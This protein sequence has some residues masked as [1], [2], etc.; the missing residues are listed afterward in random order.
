MSRAEWISFAALIISLSSAAAAWS[1]F[2]M[3]RRDRKISAPT[4]TYSGKL[5]A[6]SGLLKLAVVEPHR[7]AWLLQGLAITRPDGATIQRP[8]IA[9][10]VHGEPETRERISGPSRQLSFEPPADQAFVW[11]NAMLTT[12][13]EV[14]VT[15]CAKANHAVSSFYLMR[16]DTSSK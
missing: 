1:M 6:G 4:A 3:H 9:Y 10:N 14:R 7:A 16:I 11:L 13:V 15:L 8:E 5:T 12:F 2:R